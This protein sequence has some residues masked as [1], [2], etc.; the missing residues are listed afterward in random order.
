M[1]REDSRR[2]ILF[3]M[4]IAISAAEY[5]KPVTS[6]GGLVDGRV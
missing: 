3:D 1:V 2:P 4:D 6:V 5:G